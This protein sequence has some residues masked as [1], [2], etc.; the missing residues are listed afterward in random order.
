MWRR[1]RE[2]TKMATPS[3]PAVNNPQQTALRCSRIIRAVT[4]APDPRPGS[5]SFLSRVRRRSQGRLASTTARSNGA[6]QVRSGC[7][8]VLP[9]RLLTGIRA[10]RPFVGFEVKRETLWKYHIGEDQGPT[11]GATTSG[12]LFRSGNR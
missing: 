8:Q 9:K 4:P 2:P 11:R 7:S 3:R 1:L 6:F 5:P 10:E 12:A